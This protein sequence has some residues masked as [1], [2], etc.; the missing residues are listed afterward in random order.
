MKVLKIQSRSLPCLLGEEELKAKSRELATTVQEIA[1]E[2]IRQKNIKDQL[3]ATLSELMSR[4]TRLAGEVARGEI[5]RE[6]DVEHHLIGNDSVKEI[7][8][9]TGEV[10]L[11]RKIRDDERQLILLE[12]AKEKEAREKAEKEEGKK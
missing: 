8:T 9:D 3:K 10:M 4:E 5:Y 1:G 12:E 11:T 6:V 7:R 2:E